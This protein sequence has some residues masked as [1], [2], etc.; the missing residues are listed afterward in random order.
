MHCA[1]CTFSD[2]PL[3]HL[4]LRLPRGFRCPCELC[5]YDICSVYHEFPLINIHVLFEDLCLRSALTVGILFLFCIHFPIDYVA[6]P[7]LIYYFCSYLFV[8]A[9]P[10]PRSIAVKQC[11][12]YTSPCLHGY[13]CVTVSCSDEA[14]MLAI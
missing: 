5:W 11:R 9:P 2:H 14:T 3:L 12:F 8:Y 10:D 7:I 1:I 4:F 13:D 6:R